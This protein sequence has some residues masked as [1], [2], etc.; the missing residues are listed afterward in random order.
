MVKDKLEELKKLLEHEKK[1]LIKG[2]SGEDE[3]KEIESI[4]LQKFEIIKFL[5]TRESKDFKNHIQLVK[6]IQSLNKEIEKLIV[7]NLK[8]IESI[9]NE[10][11]PQRETTYGGKGQQSLFQKKA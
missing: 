9:L 5:S 7:N 3:A 10:L 4:E 11:F 6:E 2:V 1:L 8:F